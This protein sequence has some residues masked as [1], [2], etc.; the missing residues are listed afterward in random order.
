[1]WADCHMHTP[2]CG[3]AHG[4]P[5]D[6]V[7]A[8]AEAGL[9]TITFS[10]H[11]PMA[12][13]EGF[14]GRGIRMA[15]DDLPRYRALVDEAR[16]LG[17]SLGVEV[18]CGIEAEYFPD[19]GAMES[20]SRTLAENRFDFILGSVHHQLPIFQDFI[21]EQGLLDDAAIIAA[22]FEMLAEAAES[23]RYHSLAHPD[24]IRIYGTVEPFDPADYAEPIHKALDR[25]AAT[26]CCLEVNTSGLIK[27]VF[28]MH[29]A[30]VILGWARERDIPITLGSDSHLPEQVG[31]FFEPVTATLRAIGY[32]HAHYFRKG[33]RCA[34]PLPET[35]VAGAPE[36]TV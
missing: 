11:I 26:S 36:S 16:V 24:L 5:V 21:E 23:G 25:I 3:H 33:Q 1:M 6:F 14:R 19:P 28:E 29:P 8:A 34:Y 7:R 9:A 10:C 2:L 20:M 4:E 18:L 30:P 13:E 12:D 17:Q 32:T 35:S 31:Q 27:G 15:L 22:Y